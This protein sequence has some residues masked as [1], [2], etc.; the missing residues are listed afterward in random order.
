MRQQRRAQTT[1]QQQQCA[2]QLLQQLLELNSITQAKHIAVYLANDG[3]LDL[4]PL[5]HW[6]WQHHI[7]ESA[8]EG[9]FIDALDKL[10]NTFVEQRTEFLLQKARAGEMNKAE[11]QELQALLN[12]QA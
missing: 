1:T 3:E 4:M 2:Q 6:C 7:E 10:L 12:A 8:A 11:K 9:V 5:I